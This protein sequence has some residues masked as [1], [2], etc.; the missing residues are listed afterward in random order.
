MRALVVLLVLFFVADALLAD[1]LTRAVQEQ[2]TAQG[3]YT[4]PLDGRRSEEFIKA[5][6]AYQQGHD[7]SA[8]GV[9]DK[10]T[11]KAL[12]DESGLALPQAATAPARPAASVSPSSPPSTPRPSV[13]PTGTPWISPVP[14]STARSSSTLSP[15]PAPTLTP[16]PTVSAPSPTLVPT[17]SA[18]SPTSTPAPSPSPT[19]S[20]APPS[21]ES[22]QFSNERI[23]SFLR[24]FLKAGEGKYVT[25]QLRFFSFPVDYF[26]HGKVNA[27]FVRSD[28]LRYMRRWPR[29][30]YMFTEPPK[31]IAVENE[32]A[33]VDFTIAFTVQRG[34]RQAN[35]RTTNRVTLRESKGELKIIAIKEQ[36]VADSP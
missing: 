33:T 35:G 3:A 2:L 11:A 5:L 36:R 20:A 29:R 30:R 7:L 9:I 1:E 21:A 16:I 23:T 19:E 34:K 8:T 14:A 22:P 25:P 12:D 13:A 10:A 27:Q 4:G 32:T 28:T 24:A 18:T 26:G 17:A 6:K 15:T 31:P